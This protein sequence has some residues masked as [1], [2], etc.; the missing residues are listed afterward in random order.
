V[1][2]RD[3]GILHLHASEASWKV[4]HQQRLQRVGLPAGTPTTADADAMMV[5]IAAKRMVFNCC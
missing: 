2:K 5:L 3:D 4:A 1:F